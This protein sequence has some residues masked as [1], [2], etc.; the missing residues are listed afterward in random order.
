MS[1]IP[2]LVLVCF[3]FMAWGWIFTRFWVL[4]APVLPP[5]NHL[6]RARWGFD[7]CALIFGAFLILP[8]FLIS[9]FLVFSSTSDLKTKS[10]TKNVHVA[11]K[12]L[13]SEEVE[14]IPD[15]S[16]V[17]EKNSD[18]S[19]KYEM[20]TGKSV[21]FK[22]GV[23]TEARSITETG[24]EIPETELKGIGKIDSEKADSPKTHHTVMEFLVKTPSLKKYLFIFCYAAILAPILEEFIFRL[25]FQ[26]WLDARE[27]EIF[28]RRKGNGWRS[29]LVTTVLFCLMHYRSAESE[30]P[31][32]E[33]LG[34]QFGILFMVSISVLLFG[35]WLL[36]GKLGLSFRE[37]GLDLSHWKSDFCLGILAFAAFALPSY[38]L[39]G[40]V[41][42][43]LSE[44]CASDFIAL[45]PISL[46]FG[47]LYW[48]TRR[49][50]PSIVTHCLFNGFSLFQL[51]WM[52][53]QQ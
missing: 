34:I 38:L 6:R 20:E 21:S 41:S 45:F 4:G 51:F 32:E 3:F 47:I 25:L 1:S 12:T 52:F 40:L 33:I 36:H 24:Q 49:L 39:Q 53:L 13:S 37:I 9:F 17:A 23:E 31:S 16:I 35:I 15:S 10:E 50:L 18:A 28:A 8:P 11:V 26:G 22:R 14:N 48:R 43:L 2:F 46:I 19:E 30:Y 29:V 5:Q 27:R 42:P 44:Y 7:A